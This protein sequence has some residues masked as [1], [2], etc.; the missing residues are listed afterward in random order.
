[1]E[2]FL[3]WLLVRPVELL[4]KLTGVPTWKIEASFIFAV[5]SGVALAT[6]RPWVEWLGVAA[7][8]LTFHH[9]SVANRLEE[10]EGERV[11]KG[12]E[13]TVDCY[14]WLQ[15][16]FYGKEAVWFVYFLLIHAYSALVGVIIFFFYGR[17]RSLWRLYHP[18][19]EFTREKGT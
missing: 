7:V 12:G 17:W 1:M 11:R 16:Y 2:T 3:Y 6:H 4:K 15:R 9:A 19:D 14:R 18:I 10:M 5:L 8:T 13:A